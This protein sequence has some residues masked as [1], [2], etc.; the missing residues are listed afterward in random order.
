MLKILTLRY[1]EW[2]HVTVA[3]VMA[4]MSTSFLKAF[5]TIAFLMVHKGVHVFMAISQLFIYVNVP[6]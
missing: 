3:Q 6:I 5:L 4:V 1:N 2:M